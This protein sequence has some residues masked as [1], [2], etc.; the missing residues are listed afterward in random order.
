MRELP[1]ADAKRDFKRVLDAAERG[2]STLITRNGRP[3]AVVG[4]APAPQLPWH[5]PRP[6]PKP[7][8]PGGLL[9]MA[10]MLADWETIEEDIAQIIAERQLDMGRPPPNLD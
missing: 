2:E 9:A 5:E 4:P 10:G 6:L 1:V 8:K 7:K 3:T